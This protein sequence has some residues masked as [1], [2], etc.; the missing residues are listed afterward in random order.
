[1]EGK[2]VEWYFGRF[3][4]GFCMFFFLNFEDDNGIK[5]RG[6][7]ESIGNGGFS[8]RTCWFLRKSSWGKWQWL[9]THFLS[10]NNS[11]PN[12]PPPYEYIEDELGVFDIFIYADFPKQCEFQSTISTP[13]MNNWWNNWQSWSYFRIMIRWFIPYPIWRDTP[14]DSDNPIIDGISDNSKSNHHPHPSNNGD[15]PTTTP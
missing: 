2:W 10:V 14:I 12:M 11:F 4:I 5:G 1:M 6:L 3:L 9:L 8:M 13:H 7:W 15:H